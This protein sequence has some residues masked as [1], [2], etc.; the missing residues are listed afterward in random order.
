MLENITPLP[1]KKLLK[2][3]KSRN[4]KKYKQLLSES[5]T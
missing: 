4:R 5:N 3:E 1:K 2:E